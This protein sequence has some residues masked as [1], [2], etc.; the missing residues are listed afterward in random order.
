MTTELQAGSTPNN[1]LRG[2]ILDMQDYLDREETLIDNYLDLY[3]DLLLSGKSK[4]DAL[5]VVRHVKG[6]EN[7]YLDALERDAI[8]LQLSFKLN[9]LKGIGWN[10]MVNAQRE[11][12]LWNNGMDVKNGKTWHTMDRRVR[13]EG[14]TEVQTVVYGAERKDDGWLHA[15]HPDTGKRLCSDEALM[16]SWR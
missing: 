2:E 8:H 12:M 4:R 15:R 5:E 9:D 3:T 13:V 14:G 16:Q 7:K 1:G 6:Q 10:G 11:E